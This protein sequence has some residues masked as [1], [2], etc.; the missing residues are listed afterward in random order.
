MRKNRILWVTLGVIFILAILY[1]ITWKAE[2]PLAS[3]KLNIEN[4]ITLGNPKAPVQLVI[5]EEPKCP[6]CKKFTIQIFPKLKEEYI[7]QSLITY[8]IIPVSFLPHSM[9]AAISWL[10]VFD[11][12]RDEPNRNILFGYIDEMYA[13]QPPESEDWATPA[14]LEKIA[15]SNSKIKITNL[16]KCLNNEQ[17]KKQIEQNNA[18]G[19]KLMKGRLSTPALFIDGELVDDLSYSNVQKKIDTALAKKKSRKIKRK[20]CHDH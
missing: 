5:F 2:L 13:K 17:F 14:F 10:C 16:D 9:P 19:A 12:E 7:N 6:A 3:K 4:Q 1:Y 11:Q 20:I 8:T 18:Y 15:K